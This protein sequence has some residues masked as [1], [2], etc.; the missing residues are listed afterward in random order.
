MEATELHL[1]L[2]EKIQTQHHCILIQ[3]VLW[4]RRLF[5]YSDSK[6]DGSNKKPT[7]IKKQKPAKP[8]RKTLAKKTSGVSKQAVAS[9]TNNNLDR[10]TTNLV[11][12]TNIKIYAQRFSQDTYFVNKAVNFPK[13]QAT[14]VNGFLQWK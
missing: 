4:N 14:M 6:D 2:H 5:Q 11:L 10:I 8:D 9:I 3:I 13:L 7:L 12:R 1:D